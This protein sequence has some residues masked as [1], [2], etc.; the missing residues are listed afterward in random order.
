MTTQERFINCVR[1]ERQ[2]QEEKWGIQIHSGHCWVSIMAEEFG[3]FAKHVNEEETGA[4]M[5]ELVQI[6]AVCCAAWEQ[7]A[8]G[9]A[10]L[11]PA[12]GVCGQTPAEAKKGADG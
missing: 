3:E 5:R 9:V 12:F 8:D 11:L 10:D 4:A 1:A 7:Q 6:A 2:F